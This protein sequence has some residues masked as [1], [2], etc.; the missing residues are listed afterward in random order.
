MI[1]TPLIETLLAGMLIL[2]V[3]VGVAGTVVGVWAVI[4]VMLHGPESEGAPPPP[5]PAP[6]PTP[7]PPVP[8][9]D[10]D[11][12][13]PSTEHHGEAYAV[14]VVAS[15][16]P[17]FDPPRVCHISAYTCSADQLTRAGGNDCRVNL[18]VGYGDTYN[19][20]REQA[21]YQLRTYPWLLWV[22]K[23][24]DTQR[25][26]LTPGDLCHACG[27]LLPKDPLVQEARKAVALKDGT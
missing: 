1:E 25:G 8:I 6:A 4:G 22:A 13:R 24:L 27:G 10:P 7:T 21:E 20:A 16:D 11:A 5:A 12:P 3:V 18:V 2:L 14:Y 15:L 9:T 17:G 23:W 26:Y 19:E